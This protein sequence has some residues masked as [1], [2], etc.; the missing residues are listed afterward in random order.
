MLDFITAGANLPFTV[1]LAMVLTL[2]IVEAIGLALGLSASGALDGAFDFEVGDAD[3]SELA[4][5]SL[6]DR[7]L[8]W[9]HFGRIPVLIVIATFLMCFGAIGLLVQGTLWGTI[10]LLLPWWIAAPLAVPASLPAVRVFG[11]F[12]ARVLPKDETSAV[13]Q[14][15]LVGRV[16]T[17]VIGT[18]ERGSPAQA[19]VRDQHG[20]THYVMVEPDEADARFAQGARALIVAH[21]G[22]SYRVIHTDNPAL[23]PEA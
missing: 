5:Q 9:L 17:I 20:Q 7:F 3:G 22:T 18:A 23:T 16:A 2:A 8:G 19:K 14:A 13:S 1:A 6:T 10:G 21:A 4:A 12:L 11:G 15:S